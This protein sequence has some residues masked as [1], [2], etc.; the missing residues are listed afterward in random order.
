MKIG[1]LLI[2]FVATAGLSFS[3][4][5]LSDQPAY[6]EPQSATLTQ[7]S[8]NPVTFPG[9]A[10]GEPSVVVTGTQGTLSNNALSLTVDVS[11]GLAVSRVENK[12]T[13]E[14]VSFR[15]DQLFAF[16]YG[17][18]KYDLGNFTAGALREVDIAPADHDTG[19]FADSY[20]GKALTV[21]FSPKDTLPEALQALSLSYRAELLAGSNYVR[22]VLTMSNGGAAALD[23]T[24][25]YMVNSAAI[26]GAVEGRDDGSPIVLG[27]DGAETAWVG[28]ENPLAKVSVSDGV[29]ISRL[30]RANDLVQGNPWDIAT[31]IGV[32]PQGQL[33]R[34]FSYY[35]ERERARARRTFLH[36]QSWFDLKPGGAKLTIDHDQMLAAERLF[37]S[38]MNARGAAVDS[39]WVD[40]GWDYLRDP[41][42]TNEAQL[43]VW[44]FDPVEFPNGFAEDLEVMQAQG[45]KLSV[46]MSPFG[47]YGTSSARRTQIGN[48]KLSDADNS[49]NPWTSSNKVM[50]LSDPVYF[51]YFRDRV[52]AMIDSGVLGFKFDG[53]AQ[54]NLFITGANDNLVADYEALFDL[55]QQ[56]RAHEKDV[57]INATV[58]TWGSPYWLWYA[59]S[60]YRDGNDAGQAGQG[61][62]QEK[63]VTYRDDM[64]HQN[65]IVENPLMPINSVM[66]HGVILSD[67]TDGQIPNQPHDF[68]SESVRSGFANDLKNFFSMGIG[69]QELYLRSTFFDPEVIGEENAN[70]AWDQI[71]LN[72]RW[73]RDNVELLTDTHWIG[74][75]PAAGEV[76]GT[77]AWHNPSGAENDARAMIAVR[78]PSAAPAFIAVN[79]DQA[80]EVPAG[81]AQRFK[82]VERD[83]AAEPWVSS[84]DAPYYIALD[85]FEVLL[86]EGVP[87]DE[88]PTASQ[89]PEMDPCYT[90]IA[91][92]DWEVSADSAQL[93]GNEKDPASN[94]IDGN[95]ATIWHTQWTPTQAPYP[96][97]LQVDMGRVNEVCRLGYTPRQNATI[98]NGDIKGYKLEVSTDGQ[99]WETIVEAADFSSDKTEKFIEIP[100]DKRSFRYFKLTATSAHNGSNFAGGAEI[101]AY[102]VQGVSEWLER[103]NWQ[104]TASDF[105]ATGEQ[106]GNSGHPEHACDGVISTQWHS[107]YNPSVAPMPHWIQVDTGSM[108]DISALRYTPRQDAY[109]ANGIVANYSVQYSTDG[110]QWQDAAQGTLTD[111]S[112]AV[113]E[114]PD[115]VRARYVRFNAL[116]AQNGQ[117]FA[118]VAEI[119]L[120]GQYVLLTPKA[121]IFTDEDGSENDTYTIPEVP[122]VRYL[123]NGS[124][125]ASGVYSLPA[126]QDIVQITAAA[127]D[128][129]QLAEGEWMWEHT[130]SAESAQPE[131]I[132]TAVPGAA[133]NVSPGADDPASCEVAPFVQLTL[134]EGVVY[135]VR[136][137]D[138]V[139]TPDENGRVAYGYGETVIVSATALEGYVLPEGAQSEWT[140]TAPTRAELACDAESGTGEPGTG[141]PGTG[142]P[143]GS[144]QPGTGEDTGTDQPGTG[145]GEGTDNP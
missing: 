135:T 35:V 21:D 33:R 91:R 104:C 90:A 1:R 142:E 64:V 10:P 105:E 20:S 51:N 100:Q 68:N 50:R 60:I 87:T 69:L 122:G 107:R 66:N 15:A 75:D 39:Y 108:A 143:G 95:P 54:G 145:T 11:D 136:V 41:R 14:Q 93:T 13:S 16:T 36:F 109:P 79:A 128:G 49:N 32:A 118:G 88:E 99:A 44:S 29:A 96:H 82:F 3:L 126:G 120:R 62:S 123:I 25:V 70:W 78:N 103:E 83:G 77:A 132:V 125:V 31:T 89:E 4:I 71:A 55:M 106:N 113:I 111:A 85:P 43:N 112:R 34:S 7:P 139:L 61:N 8:S 97:W 102:G 86:F 141:E 72:A 129:W 26:T 24:N 59:D 94:M 47:G 130:F 52:F 119:D 76:Y 23:I 17:G 81:Q 37:F 144:E 57:W 9:A 6:A 80:L 127:A 38:Q 92:A 98:T 27:A 131:L 5:P 65:M 18:V 67:R 138:R 114:F 12:L 74:G 53:I 137:G 40:D 134:A 124:A 22:H 133:S 63:Y 30:P 101:N 84:D 28:G 56:M 58:G 2:A 46:W 19:S 110:Q 140:W 121:P 73:A 115:T 117:Q 45:A 42:Q 48:S 116:S